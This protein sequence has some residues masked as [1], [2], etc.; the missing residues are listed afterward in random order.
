MHASRLAQAHDGQPARQ[1]GAALG[2][3]RGRQRGPAGE[4]IEQVQALLD[5]RPDR[6]RPRQG[7]SPAGGIE[8]DGGAFL[9][10]AGGIAH[11]CDGTL[12]GPGLDEADDGLHRE[13]QQRGALDIGQQLVA[14]GPGP[15]RDGIRRKAEHALRRG[16]GGAG[17]EG[18][19]GFGRHPRQGRHREQRHQSHAQRGSTTCIARPRHHGAP[20][21]R[22]WN[23]RDAEMPRSGSWPEPMRQSSGV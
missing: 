16:S 5:E 21:R 9:G 10:A 7:G 15:D 22:L 23:G 3:R 12:A 13:P 20:P 19:D 11:H 18:G 1:R 4:R 6:R 14:I 17:L 2:G 8:Q